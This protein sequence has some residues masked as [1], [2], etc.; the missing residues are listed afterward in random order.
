[1]IDNSRPQ[2]ADDIVAMD[3]DR[4]V[5]RIELSA[6][7]VKLTP[8]MLEPGQFV[9]NGNVYNLEDCDDYMGNDQ[10]LSPLQLFANGLD[11]CAEMIIDAQI[12]GQDNF[13]HTA[14]EIRDEAH[15]YLVDHEYGFSTL[16]AKNHWV[17]GW[18]EAWIGADL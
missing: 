10:Q 9:R 3:G 16:A 17:D 11:T 18:V 13:P 2:Q 12:A 8:Q 6:Y 7:P 14:A 4:Y 5:R 1:M 15:H